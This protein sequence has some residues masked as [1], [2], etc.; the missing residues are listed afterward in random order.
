MNFGCLCMIKVN[1]SITLKSSDGAAV[2]ILDAGGADLRVVVIQANGVTFGR[3]SGG[4]TMTNARRDGLL[5]RG[6]HLA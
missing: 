6:I 1:K 4:F 2:T 3:R 5:L